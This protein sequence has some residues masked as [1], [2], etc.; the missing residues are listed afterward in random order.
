M[1]ILITGHKG[2]IGS[3]LFRELS[4]Y[5]NVSGI[6]LYDCDYNNKTKKYDVIIHCA[7]HCLIREV[8]KTPGLALENINSTFSTLELAKIHK[9][10]FI[11]FSSSR[12][13]HNQHNPYIASKRAGEEL[14]KAYAKCYG[15]EYIII[16]PET[17]WGRTNDNYKRVIPQWIETIKN[18]RVVT[19]YGDKNK[20]L[21]PIHVEDF[22]EIFIEVLENFNTYKGQE[23][24]ISGRILKAVNIVKMIGKFY[25]RTPKI[26]FKPAEKTQ[27]QR[28]NNADFISNMTFMEQLRR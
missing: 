15:I 12:V 1:N 3:H 2:L 23:I 26:R 25:N 10:K 9:A 4:K 27:P 5:H 7:A 6:D 19:I 17:V 8:I 18:N 22:V 20:Q 21:S 14:V 28:C 16:R 24:S 13:E 11:Y